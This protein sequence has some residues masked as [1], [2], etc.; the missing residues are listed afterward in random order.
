ML[1]LWQSFPIR[2]WFRI[3]G[4]SGCISLP[5]PPKTVVTGC[6]L[7]ARHCSDYFE[8]IQLFN[9]HNSGRWALL[10]P[11]FRCWGVKSQCCLEWGIERIFLSCRESLESV[12]RSREGPE[13]R[14][15]RG[16]SP[17]S[18]TL[19]RPHPPA[20]VVLPP[21]RYVHT[22]IPT[23]VLGAHIPSTQECT[24]CAISLCQYL[25]KQISTKMSIL[26]GSLIESF[27]RFWRFKKHCEDF[28][29]TGG[30]ESHFR[31]TRFWPQLNIS[32]FS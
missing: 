29:Q 2:F 6:F 31:E 11:F 8:C 26:K 5:L 20:W 22:L 24:S 18:R 14:K 12:N 4:L 16:G 28:L 19:W 3:H 9:S 27:L 17:M 7:C 23:P 32:H 15:R 21:C 13:R 1:C 25:L 10:S 30:K